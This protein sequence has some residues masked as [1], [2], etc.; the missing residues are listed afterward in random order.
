M[1]H[2]DDRTV[3]AAR[4]IEDRL[5]SLREWGVDLSLTQSALACTPD[6][7]LDILLGLLALKNGV[8]DAET[9]Q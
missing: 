7:R 9:A 5:K 3:P 2:S 4:S 1:Q 8:E 6:E